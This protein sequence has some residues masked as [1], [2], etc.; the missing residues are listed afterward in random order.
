MQRAARLTLCCAAWREHGRLSTLAPRP[1]L[2]QGDASRA[3]LPPD[4]IPGL[5]LPR[6]RV[7]LIL[8]GRVP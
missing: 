4:A 6:R 1:D 8:C 5:R 3:V 7:A 2:E